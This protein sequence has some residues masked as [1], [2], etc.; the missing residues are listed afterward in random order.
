MIAEREFLTIR[1]AVFG[2]PMRRPSSMKENE[3]KRCG[4][5][6]RRGESCRGLAMINGRCRMHGGKS[7]CWFTHPRYKHGLYSKYS[8][9]GLQRRI[10]IK[11]RKEWRAKIKSVRKMSDEQV[12]AE[13]RHILRLLGTRN[14]CPAE[15]RELLLALY[16]ASLKSVTEREPSFFL[17]Q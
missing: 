1:A 5:K 14:T 2:Y 11:K 9:A 17:R 7:L 3:V 10:A 13:A 4:A 12:V 16:Q 15:T 6:T 8:F